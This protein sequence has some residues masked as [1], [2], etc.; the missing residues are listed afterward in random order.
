MELVRDE[1][2][3]PAEALAAAADDGTKQQ[4]L[5]RVVCFGELLVDFVPLVGGLPV[6]EEPGFKAG[7][8]GAPA[9]VAVGI[10]KL[11]VPAA[12]IGKV[13]DDEFGHALANVLK[14]NGVE[15]RMLIQALPSSPSA[16]M[17]NA[18]SFSTATHL[19]I[20]SW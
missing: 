9:N 10:R 1:Q 7:A 19:P 5:S 8:G 6:F 16:A 13:G 11:G 17:G 12:F 14:E 2:P 20:C 18:P 3:P 4:E 15:T